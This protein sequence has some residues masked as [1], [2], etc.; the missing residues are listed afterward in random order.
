[1]YI[2]I[3]SKKDECGINEKGMYDIAEGIK[4]NISLKKLWLGKNKFDANGLKYL[5]KAFETNKSIQKL[6]ICIFLR[7]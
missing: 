3:N 1:M 6:E 4:S 5:K 7:F 2:F